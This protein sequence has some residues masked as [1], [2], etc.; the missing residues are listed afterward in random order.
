MLIAVLT[1]TGRTIGYRLIIPETGE[2]RDTGSR[3]F[4]QHADKVYNLEV[5]NGV[6][7]GKNGSLSRYTEI[8][9]DTKQVMSKPSIVILSKCGDKYKCSDHEGRIRVLASQQVIAFAEKNGGIANG[10]IL[11]KGHGKEVSAIYGTYPI[12]EAPVVQTAKQVDK[13]EE[14]KT[15]PAPTED[16]RPVHVEV[17]RLTQSERERINEKIK[18]CLDGLNHQQLK[19]ATTIDG[20]IRLIAGA[21]TGK[22]NTLTKRIA[23]IVS[24]G[25]E[26]GR[27]LSVTFTNKAAA[28]MRERTA[29]LLDISERHL[30]M[31]TFHSLCAKILRISVDSLGWSKNFTLGGTSAL[32]EMLRDLMTTDPDYSAISQTD[33]TYIMKK[34]MELSNIMRQTDSCDYAKY[35]V[36]APLPPRHKLLDLISYEQTRDLAIE[37]HRWDY[38]KDDNSP[39]KCYIYHLFGY[40]RRIKYLSFD[41]LIA[42][43]VYMFKIKPQI[44][45]YWQNQFDYI[46]VDEFQDTNQLQY[47]LVEMLGAACGNLFVVG[48]PDQSIYKFR[49]AC[50]EI[51]IELDK[52]LPK[53]QDIVMDINYRSFA[54]IL[55]AGNEVIKLSRNRIPKNL[56]A[57]E[58]HKQGDL[59]TFMYSD[60]DK[61]VV[62]NIVET[63]KK[64]IADG[65]PPAEIAI[66]YRSKNSTMLKLVA[67]RLTI[68][69]VKF[70][71]Y[72]GGGLGKS[73]EYNFVINLLGAI[74]NGNNHMHMLNALTDVRGYRKSKKVTT[75]IKNRCEQGASCTDAFAQLVVNRDFNIESYNSLDN[76]V[77]F[78]EEAKKV[79]ADPQLKVS[80][81]TPKLFDLILNVFTSES[82]D[83]AN[84]ICDAVR[85][86]SNTAINEGLEDNCS[87]LLTKLSLDEDE[88][89]E[90]KDDGAV[91]IMTIH[92]SKGLEFEVVF[93]LNVNTGVFPSGKCTGDDLDEEVRLAYVA[94]TRAKKW[95]YICSHSGTNFGGFPTSPSMLVCCLD[96]KKLNMTGATRAKWVSLKRDAVYFFERARG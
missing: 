24:T 44:L 18:G 67:D 88:A 96:D 75:Y 77:E 22:T 89:E 39:T 56:Q 3:G 54:P 7:K 27:I 90:E 51:L 76:I 19:A 79:D 64:K 26:P 58:A 16:Y 49:Q 28:E 33:R 84:L 6:V 17:E 52:K 48:D 32:K 4:N 5:K 38:K 74:V 91:Q 62:D 83:I 94:Y 63:I 72:G 14:P 20:N 85:N 61:I 92:K 53:L 37:E 35:L 80:T 41:D 50:P 69:G 34:F 8:D 12:E 31:Q 87:E 11:D 42:L 71:V 60:S 86:F 82:E 93:V 46:Q 2:T 66:L 9:Y 45:N 21:G 81:L 36:D 40:Q 25:A 13:V 29:N 47:E 95:L 70:R 15:T 30:R 78:I 1:R 43:T 55:D 65:I 68:S 73:K 10:K 23:Y 59:P 57:I